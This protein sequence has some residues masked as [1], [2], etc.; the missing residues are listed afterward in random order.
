[1]DPILPGTRFEASNNKGGKFAPGLPDTLVVHYTA[2]LTLQGAVRTLCDPAS[3]ASAH[4][5]V[6]RDGSIVQLVGIDTIAW[7]AGVSRHL[8]RSGL[9]K[10]SVGIEIVNAG[11]LNRTAAGEFVTWFGARVDPAQA[12][13]LVHRNEDVMSWWHAYTEE[14][15]ESVCELARTLVAGLGLKHILGHEEV[16]PGIKSDP[17]PAFPLDP[18][19]MRLLGTQRDADEDAAELTQTVT[20]VISA[21]LLNTRTGPSTLSPLASV[22]LRRGTAVV[23]TSAQAGWLQIRSPL[24]A[25]VKRE[26]VDIPAARSSVP[27][28]RAAASAFGKVPE[29]R[30]ASLAGATEGDLQ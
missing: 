17:G 16:T 9:N 2:G 26:Y 19:R 10:Y 11:R 29:L 18:L 14:Q 13:Q 20:G 24:N 27:A 6:D 21:S 3:K 1:M 22:P 7:H 28:H 5:V 25:W 8:S 4:F 23:I 30:P 15:V 12:L